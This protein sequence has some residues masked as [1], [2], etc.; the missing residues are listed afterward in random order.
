MFLD[1]VLRKVLLRP[2]L[3]GVIFGSWRS[4]RR[5]VDI[6]GD[7]AVFETIQQGIDQGFSLEQIIPVRVIQ[8]R[9]KN[10]CSLSVAFAH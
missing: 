1:K 3:W 9:G 10:G 8:V 6:D 5:A 2:R 7:A 4:Q